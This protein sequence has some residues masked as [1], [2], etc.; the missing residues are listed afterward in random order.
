MSL[1]LNLDI[2]GDFGDITQ[3]YDILE[4]DRD[5]IISVLGQFKVFWIVNLLEV[6]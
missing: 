5:I 2:L 3:I 4:V 1:E 6:R